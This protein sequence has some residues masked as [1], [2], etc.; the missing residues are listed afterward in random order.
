MCSG[1]V[2]FQ[3]DV[4]V[5]SADMRLRHASIHLYI[6]D[7]KGECC[8]S[9]PQ[10]VVQFSP[11]CETLSHNQKNKD[12]ELRSVFATKPRPPFSSQALKTEVI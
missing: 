8:A 2:S 3:R 1:N 10:S 9:H 4:S 11:V 5:S 12:T 7:H 6:G